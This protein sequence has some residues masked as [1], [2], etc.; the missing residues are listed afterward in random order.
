MDKSIT[1]VFNFLQVVLKTKLVNYYQKY[2]RL[3]FLY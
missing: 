1:P 2:F 3:I